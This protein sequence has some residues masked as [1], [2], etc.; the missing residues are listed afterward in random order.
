MTLKT[1]LLFLD[2]SYL[3]TFVTHYTKL[4]GECNVVYNVHNLIYLSDDASRYGTTDTFS[5]FPF[6]TKLGF[7]KKLVRP[8]SGNRGSLNIA[9]L[10]EDP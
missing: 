5:A 3:L 10:T 6:E 9:L 4:Y 2:N 1:L 8:L 7:I